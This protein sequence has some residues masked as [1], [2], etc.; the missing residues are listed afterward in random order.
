M[1]S[2]PPLI[3]QTGEKLKALTLRVREAWW[4]IWFVRL[5]IGLL[6]ATALMKLLSI[7]AGER[8]LDA[9]DPILGMPYK[10]AMFGGAILEIGVAILLSSHK[11]WTAGLLALSWLGLAFCFYHLALTVFEPGALCPCLGTLY[12]RLGIKL[13]AANAIAQVLAVFFL[14]GPLLL[15]GIKWMGRKRFTAENAKSAEAEQFAR[16]ETGPLCRT[17][18]V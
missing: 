18:T 5:A 6:L 13:A 11:R 7:A 14:V 16:P 4:E 9:N 10:G 3:A 17:K 2:N 12:G 15:W 8:I 1:P